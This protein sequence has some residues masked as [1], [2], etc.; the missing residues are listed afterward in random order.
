M[1][2]WQVVTSDPPDGTAT[3]TVGDNRVWYYIQWTPEEAARAF[4]WR[5]GEAT[6]PIFGLLWGPDGD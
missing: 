1:H 3:M 6:R 5:C 2:Y 4:A